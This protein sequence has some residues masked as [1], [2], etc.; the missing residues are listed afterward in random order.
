[1][2]SGLKCDQGSDRVRTK[3]DSP[4][5]SPECAD[6]SGASLSSPTP[7]GN[8]RR[9]ELDRYVGLIKVVTSFSS[10]EPP[11]PAILPDRWGGTRVQLAPGG[12]CLLIQGRDGLTHN[13]RKLC[14]CIGRR[15]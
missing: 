12:P 8:D 2:A 5:T 1:M 14:W 7:L 3:S 13:S 6:R 10:D 11:P 15:V 4:R 9:G